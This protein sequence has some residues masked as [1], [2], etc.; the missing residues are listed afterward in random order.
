MNNDI[1]NKLEESIS[2]EERL[3]LRLQSFCEEVLEFED[4]CTEVEDREAKI[5]NKANKIAQKLFDNILND[6]EYSLVSHKIYP[7]ESKIKF[8]IIKEEDEQPQAY[9]LLVENDGFTLEEV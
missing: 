8:K 5:L 2:N 1:F 7:V 9:I 4:D 6:S 3:V